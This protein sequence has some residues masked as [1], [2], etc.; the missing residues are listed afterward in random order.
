MCQ[1][2]GQ[3]LCNLPFHDLIA[4]KAEVQGGEV[5]DPGLGFDSS[6]CVPEPVLFPPGHVA[7]EPSSSARATQ[8]AYLCLGALDGVCLLPQ[9]ERMP[10]EMEFL[11]VTQACSHKYEYSFL[12]TRG[13]ECRSNKLPGPASPSITQL[14]SLHV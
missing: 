11:V 14:F 5:I 9:E 8:A 12:K 6:Q 2:Q 4:E 3:A 13:K 7:P 1:V 10:E